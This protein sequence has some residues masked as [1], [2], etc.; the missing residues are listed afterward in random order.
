[1]P[2]E[3]FLKGS[4]LYQMSLGSKELY[5]SNVWAW[6]IEN[7]HAFVNAFFPAFDQNAYIVLGVSRECCHRDLIIWLHKN[8]CPDGKGA[9]YLLIENK[10]KSLHSYTQLEGYTQPLWGNALLGAAFT[11]IENNLE[12]NELLLKNGETEVTWLFRPHRAIAAAL[13]QIAEGSSSGAIRS[14]LQQIDEYCSILE[15]IDALLQKALKKNE[16]KLSYSTDG[17]PL[18]DERIRLDDVFVK[19]KGADFLAYLRKNRAAFDTLCP[20]ERGFYPILSQSF[21]NKNATLDIR[22]SNWQEHCPEYLHIG[23]QI[24][25]TQYRICAE[26]NGDRHSVDEVYNELKHLWFDDSFDP[27]TNRLVFGKKTSQRAKYDCYGRGSR[28]YSFVY[29]YY[30]LDGVDSEYPALLSLLVQDMERARNV[31]KTLYAP[32]GKPAF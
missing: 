16:G 24:E 31:I 2:P 6:L 26:R 23:I 28:T 14:R 8:G 13:R 27:K 11:G 32:P 19:L 25:G 12:N 22:F 18:S 21:N 15:S 3:E 10:I 30:R 5:H 4:L 29:Q 9:Y 17:L 20:A 7:D 1:M